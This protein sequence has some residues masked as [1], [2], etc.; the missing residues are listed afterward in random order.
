MESDS[1]EVRSKALWVGGGPEWYNTVREWLW[2]EHAAVLA[3]LL[4]EKMLHVTAVR[5][6]DRLLFESR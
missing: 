2:E 5:A 1:W 4:P 6:K 3:A